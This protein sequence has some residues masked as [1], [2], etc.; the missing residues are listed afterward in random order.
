MADEK[1][2]PPYTNEEAWI[3]DHRVCAIRTSYKMTSE[4]TSQDYVTLEALNGDKVTWQIE[5]FRTMAKLTNHISA[6]SSLVEPNEYRLRER[7]EVRRAW[8]K[9]EAKDLSE[10]KRLQSKFGGNP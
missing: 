1:I 3:V 10:Y 4:D 9:K 8:E 6:T 2:P 7:V 5:S